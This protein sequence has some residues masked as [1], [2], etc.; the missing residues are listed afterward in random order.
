VLIPAPA[1]TENSS[2][3]DSFTALAVA[4][5]ALFPGALYV[6]SFERTVG[7]HW[8]VNLSD[9]VTRFLVISGMFQVLVA[10]VTFELY[11]RYVVVDPVGRGR[12]SGSFTR[13]GYTSD[14]VFTP[15]SLPR[16]PAPGAMKKPSS[17]G[18]GK[19]SH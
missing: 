11:R 3:P 10:L 9:R 2:V 14:K 15:K 17:N 8:G 16:G 19:T 4:V 5:L 7:G 12:V 13:R 6:L 1:E 18:D